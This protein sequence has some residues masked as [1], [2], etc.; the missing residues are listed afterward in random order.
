MKTVIVVH[1]PVHPRPF[2]VVVLVVWCGQVEV[3]DVR[4]AVTRA[5]RLRVEAG[6]LHRDGI[7]AVC[8]NLVLGENSPRVA[9]PAVRGSG[10]RIENLHE[11]AARIEE[12][13]EISAKLLRLRNRVG[14]A[15]KAGVANALIRE[16]EE[17]SIFAVEDLGNPD[18]TVGD[19]AEGIA[20]PLR[21]R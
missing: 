15:V 8:R 6:R 13:G 20:V 19:K 2:A 18:R 9:A 11:L 16:H 3:V 14:R 7:K 21:Y 10:K 12:P 5:A 17:Q 4:G 1:D